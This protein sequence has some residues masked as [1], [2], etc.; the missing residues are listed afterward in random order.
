ML[1]AINTILISALLLVIIQDVK[2]RAIHVLLPIVLFAAAITRYFILGYSANE[3]LM[4]ALFLILVLTGLFLYVTVKNKK[5]INPIDSSIGLG[6]IVYFVAII[7]LFFST[8]YIAFFSTGM[9]FAIVC[10]F[11]FNKNE[12]GH[13]PLAGYLSIYLVILLAINF[14]IEKELFYTHFI[15]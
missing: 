14:L 3:L 5:I 1:I 12:E 15:I 6:D 2:Y 13:I 8:T 9:L 4:T 7:P 10:H 11:L